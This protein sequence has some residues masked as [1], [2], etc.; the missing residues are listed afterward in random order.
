MDLIKSYT[1]EDPDYVFIYENINKLTPSLI[2][3]T[4]NRKEA[5]GFIL[6]YFEKQSKTCAIQL[7]F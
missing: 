7:W 4:A 3:L 2:K 1:Y 6:G 5:K